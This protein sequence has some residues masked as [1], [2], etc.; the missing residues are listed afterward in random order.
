MTMATLRSTVWLTLRQHRF[1]LVV[2][3]I[4]LVVLALDWAFVAWLAFGPVH[5]CAAAGSVPNLTDEQLAAAAA[6][7]VGLEFVLS[8]GAN[9]VLLSANSLPLFAVLIAAVPLVASEIEFGTATLSWT[10]ARSR[11]S[12][13]LPRMALLMAGVLGVGLLAGLVTDALMAQTTLVGQSPWA[14]LYAYTGRGALIVSRVL[15]VGAAGVFGGTLMGRQMQGLLFGGVIAT[16]LILGITIWDEQ[17]N[18]ANAV[19]LG[20]GYSSLTYDTQIRDLAT[21]QFVDWSDLPAAYQ[22]P[23]TPGWDAKYAWV[24][25]GIPDSQAGAVV[26]R[27]VVAYAIPM[28]LMLGLTFVVVERRKPYLS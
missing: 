8:A 11:R 24:S 13:L 25:F 27:N 21:G 28:F 2:M 16:G 22:D 20:S 15:L 19:E 3:G 4:A 26:G 9:F 14:S 7:C 1:P 10:L 5:T 23:N 18:R 17:V 6:P 12:W